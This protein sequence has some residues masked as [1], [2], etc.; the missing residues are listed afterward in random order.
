M[1]TAHNSFV[2]VPI[3]AMSSQAAG[4]YLKNFCNIFHH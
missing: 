3:V 1:L 2:P 4:V